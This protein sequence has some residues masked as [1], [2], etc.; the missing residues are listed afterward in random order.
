MESTIS[1][2]LNNTQLLHVYVQ[3]FHHDTTYIQS[4]DNLQDSTKA[5]IINNIESLNMAIVNTNIMHSPL[6]DET[7]NITKH[8]NN[9][10][11]LLRAR[12][13]RK[14]R[15]IKRHPPQDGKECRRSKTL[16]VIKIS[17]KKVINPVM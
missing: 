11:A 12:A 5:N 8:K 16:G 3:E 2:Y 1:C 13:E 9:Y 14:D 15:P 10:L 17:D 4:I 7:T 6:P